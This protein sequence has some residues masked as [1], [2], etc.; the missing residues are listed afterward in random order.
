MI[1]DTK[2]FKCGDADITPW[3][4]FKAYL[5]NKIQMWRTYVIHQV[6]RRKWSYAGHGSEI[7]DCRGTAQINTWRQHKRKRSKGCQTNDGEVRGEPDDFWKGAICRTSFSCL[8]PTSYTQF[9]F[10]VGWWPLRNLYLLRK[11]LRSCG[12]WSS[13]GSCSML[14]RDHQVKCNVFPY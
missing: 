9:C 6:R 7:R 10:S 4:T 13:S 3:E 8:L 14:V 11:I 1:V 2:S 5:W 12:S